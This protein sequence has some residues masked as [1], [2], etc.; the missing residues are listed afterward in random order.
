MPQPPR[1]RSVLTT[2]MVARRVSFALLT[3]AFTLG[4]SALAQGEPFS[5]TAITLSVL[6]GGVTLLTQ[7][8]I[9]FEKALAGVDQAFEDRFSRASESARLLDAV[10]AS[11]V[12][13]PLVTELLERAARL[14][15]AV[16]PLLK[17]VG[18]TEIVRASRFLGQLVTGEAVY[19][20]GEDRD[21]LLSLTRNARLSIDATSTTTVDGRGP[22]FAEGFWSS[23]LGN[24]YLQ[25]Q[26]NAVVRRNVEIRRLFI[27]TD[28][29]EF[30]GRLF[31]SI[32]ESQ[33]KAG[34]KILSLPRERVPSTLRPSLIDFILFD[35][36][37]SYEVIPAP[38]SSPAPEFLNT[39]L[40]QRPEHVAERRACFETLWNL[41]LDL[42][43]G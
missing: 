34:I 20:D 29:E 12:D 33:E 31:A 11:A 8:L 21:W 4:I 43:N 32:A 28:P 37:L 9:D 35:Q 18:E 10:G 14:G 23:D 17:D 24:R 27:V 41:A 36:V 42:R 19:E 38:S 39:R 1:A 26:S 6:L 30:N 13:G 7:V 15:P 3:G 40:I 25:A 22:S 16:P 2:S 5:I